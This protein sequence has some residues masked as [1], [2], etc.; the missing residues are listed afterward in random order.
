MKEVYNDGMKKHLKSIAIAASLVLIS[1]FAFTVA[2]AISVTVPTAP[3]FNYILTSTSTGAWVPVPGSG[4][5]GNCVK[6]GA[7]NSLVDLGA[8]CG[9]GGTAAYPFPG[10]GNSTSTLTQFNGGLTAYGSSTIGNGNANGGL[11]VNGYATTT[12]TLTVGTNAA[13]LKLTSNSLQDLSDDDLALQSGIAEL[14]DAVGD[15][16]ELSSG[17]GGGVE[18]E[19]SA[20]QKVL[21]YDPIS[22]VAA[23]LNTSALTAPR[24]YSFPNTAGT[25]C[26]TITCVSSLT[27]TGSSGAATFSPTTG[28]L[29]IPQYSGGSSASSTLLTDNNTFS[30]LNK[31]NNTGTTTFSGG[32]EDGSKIAAP[33]FI[34]TSSTATSTFAGGIRSTCFSTDGINCITSS[35][36]YTSTVNNTYATTTTSFYGD[37]NRQDTYTA[38]GSI[39]RPFKSISTFLSSIPSNIAAFALNLAPGAYIDVPADTFPNIPFSMFLNSGAYVAASGVT[40]PNSFVIHDGTIAGNVHESD[41]TLTTNHEFDNVVVLGNLQMDGLGLLSN[42]VLSGG[43]YFEISPSSLSN[44]SGSFIQNPIWANGATNFNDDEIATSTPGAIV[45]ATSTNYL[46]NGS[47]GNVNVL[48]ATIINTNA[49]GQGLNIPNGA[50]ST[51]NNITAATILTGGSHSLM[52]GS[53][54]TDVCDDQFNSLTG[55]FVAPE[56]SSTAAWVPCYDEDLSVLTAAAFGTTTTS[57]WP[58]VSSSATL[59]QIGLTDGSSGDNAWT[60]R[61]E[62]G[63]LA[64]GTST[65]ISTSSVDA[66][67]IGVNGTSTNE[68]G[69]NLKSGCFAVAGTCLTSGGGSTSFAWPW[70]ALNN[71]STSTNATTTPYTAPAYFASSTLASQFPYASS[72]VFSSG[73]IDNS[74]LGVL[75]FRAITNGFQFLT[76]ANTLALN[77]GS[78]RPIIGSLSLGTASSLW[79][80][81]YTSYASTTEISAFQDIKI[82]GTSTTTIQGNGATSTLQSTLVVASSSPNALVVQDQYGTQSLRVSTA[83]STNNEPRLQIIGTSTPGTL[84]Q[85]DQYGH[86]MASSTPAKPTVSC[87]PS[88]GTLS[89]TSNDDEGVITGGTLSTA[90]TLTFGAAFSQTPVVQTTGSNIFS[91][92]TAQST[93]AFTVSMVATT[94]D[95]INYSVVMP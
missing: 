93:T 11:T 17:S 46:P 15:S 36:S 92:V 54:K 42:S 84:F 12:N 8:P 44:V 32:I 60:M 61:N 88:G 86:L 87:T 14:F 20:G 77:A 80:N 62:G 4:V 72:T 50:T 24:V 79:T 39:L 63:S 10:A 81:L 26:L 9:T 71:F 66:I 95:V 40:F 33:Y 28:V 59:P 37:V 7:N 13:N 70:T 27:T 89:A 34:A 19:P 52:V 64:I 1:L 85:V 51:I 91:G 47:F 22:N 43:Q 25:F 68:N 65:A 49:A 57:A 35:G 2:S 38:D 73:E 30:G 45:T 82:G 76:G 48:G 75:I 83:S 56:A 3:G 29:N 90:C 16:I 6:W 53:A 58:I 67:L 69:I 18:L 41:N 5:S 94:G 55:A 74:G 23:S 21:I 31:F 78:L